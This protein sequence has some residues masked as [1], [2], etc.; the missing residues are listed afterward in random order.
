MLVKGNYS[1]IMPQVPVLSAVQRQVLR[2]R[3]L[4]AVIPSLLLAAQQP[5]VIVTPFAK[6]TPPTGTGKL[7]TVSL[8]RSFG[9]LAALPAGSSA[10]T[11]TEPTLPKNS[12]SAIKTHIF[13]IIFLIVLNDVR[14]TTKH[15]LLY[16]NNYTQE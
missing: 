2:S 5:D 12:A 6:G 13:S 11:F 4:Q 8:V 15:S 1:H 9:G 16:L 14:I 7:V 10:D 3:E